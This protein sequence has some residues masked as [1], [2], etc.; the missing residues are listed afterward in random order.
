M[1]KYKY[2]EILHTILILLMSTYKSQALGIIAFVLLCGCLPFDDDSSRI[3][4]DSAVRKKFVLRFPKW[5]ASLSTSAKDLLHN[6][7]EVN[8]KARYTAEQALSHPWVSGH[9]VQINNYLKSPSVIGIYLSICYNFNLSTV[10]INICNSNLFQLF[11]GA[12]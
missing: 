12:P 1:G 11:R 4:S 10:E 9:T 3:A 5:A 6:L 8:P 2:D 7:L